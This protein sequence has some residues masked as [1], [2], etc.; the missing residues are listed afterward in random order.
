MRIMRKNS[1]I[2]ALLSGRTIKKT[3][4]RKSGR[5]SA[6]K[7]PN[8]RQNTQY[9]EAKQHLPNVI[10][11]IVFDAVADYIEMLLKDEDICDKIKNYQKKDKKTKEREIEMEKHELAK[12]RKKIAVLESYIPDAMS[13]KYPISLEELLSSIYKYKKLEEIQK[14]IISQREKEM[15]EEQLFI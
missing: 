6:H 10:E 4:E 12:T 15:E 1:G 13:V 11:P 5:T 2:R 14:G 9:R 7:R 3:G 8:T